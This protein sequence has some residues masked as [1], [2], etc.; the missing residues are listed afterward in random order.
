MLLLTRFHRK[1]GGGVFATSYY[2]YWYCYYCCISNSSRVVR[3]VSSFTVLSV[4]V[5]QPYPLRTPTAMSMPSSSLQD[6]TNK[7]NGHD[8]GGTQKRSMDSLKKRCVMK[9]EKKQQSVL[10]AVLSPIVLTAH[11]KKLEPESNRENDYKIAYNQWIDRTEN[12]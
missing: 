10:F 7:D 2:W 3:T 1:G 11:Q 4:L 6:A 5:P 8:D 9:T 12:K